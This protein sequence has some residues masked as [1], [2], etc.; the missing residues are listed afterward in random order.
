MIRH[1]I[2]WKLVAE[3]SADKDAA[4]AELAAGFGALPHLIPEIK[5]L[6]IGRDID[7]TE[8]NADVVLIIDYATTA[9]LEIYQHHPDHVKVKE[10]VRR[11]ATARTAVD[12]EL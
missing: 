7:E 4:F 5:S 1:V 9:D 6:Q 10:I 11:V 2:T 8:G 3:D 12:F